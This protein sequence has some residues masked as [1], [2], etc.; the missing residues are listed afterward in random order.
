MNLVS[1]VSFSYGITSIIE[2]IGLIVAFLIAFQSLRIYRYVRDKKYRLFSTSFL[3][4]GTSYI[5]KIFSN[6]TVSYKVSIFNP[7]MIIEAFNKLTYFQAAQF[8]SFILFKSFLLLGFL[9]LFL[10]TIKIDKKREIILLIYLGAISVFISIFLDPIFNLTISVILLFLTFNFYENYQ[11]KASKNSFLVFNAFFMMFI[12]S[13][14]GTFKGF[15]L[16]VHIAESFFFLAGFTI[17]LVNHLSLKIKN[18]K[19]KK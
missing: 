1:Q 10:I 8:L 13:L 15:H 12:G 7:A 17:L 9:L 2:F 14:V 5:F 3:F 19:K 4:L 11:K 16:L 18:G 6:L